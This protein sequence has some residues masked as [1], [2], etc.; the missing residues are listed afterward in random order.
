MTNYTDI[1]GKREAK[2]MKAYTTSVHQIA[3][4]FNC[5]FH[6]EDYLKHT[7]RKLAYKHA[8]KTGHKVTVE[9]GLLTVYNYDKQP[10]L[11]NPELLPTN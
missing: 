9:T 4:C 10:P 11:E 6:N 3:Y 2:P 5:D 1:I 8:K 7:A